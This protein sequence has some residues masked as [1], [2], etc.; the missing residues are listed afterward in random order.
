MAKKP[1][2]K[3][4]EKKTVTKKAAAKKNFKDCCKKNHF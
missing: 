3:V 1:T 2:E 4:A